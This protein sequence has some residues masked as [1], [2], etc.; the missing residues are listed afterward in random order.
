MSKFLQAAIEY[1]ENGF[2]VIPVQKNKKPYIK[3][4]R[5]Q[6]ERA[7]QEQLEQWW[8]QWPEANVGI[9]TGKISGIM[10][11][12]ADSKQGQKELNKLFPDSLETPTAKSPGGWH[13][14]FAYQEGLSNTARVLPDCDIRTDG[15]YI[16]APPSRNAKGNYAWVE[17]LSIFDVAPAA[18]PKPVYNKIK[19]FNRGATNSDHNNPQQSATIRNISF[20]EGLRDESLFHIGNCL[21]KGGMDSDNALKCL[22]FIG[23]N[24][25]PPFPEKEIQAKIQSVFKRAKNKNRSLTADVREYVS[26]TWGNISATEVAQN[27]TNATLEDRKKIRVILGRLVKEKILVRVSNLNGVYR[28]VDTDIEEMNFL[29]ADTETVDLWLPFGLNEKAEIMPGNIIV[30]AGS[31]DAGKTGLLLNVIRQNMQKF[32]I[33]YFNSEMGSG[34]LN[35]RLNNFDD[36]TLDMWKFKAWER[37][38]NFADVIKPGKGKINIID[39]LEIHDN[40]Y[41]VGGRLAEIHK[42]LKDAIAIVALQKNPGAKAGLGGYR[43]L[44]KPRLYLSMDSGIVTITKCKNWATSENPNGLQ[45]RFKVAGG[46][47]FIKAQDWHRPVE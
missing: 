31:P 1:C 2:S 19:A 38:D 23:S 14:Y 34:E 29:D 32:E 9:V 16:I 42:K 26:A 24:C 8:G 25:N 22:H 27:A 11:L 40:F 10:V 43:S 37:S 28:K 6:G 3:W 20:E 45:Y 17:G 7:T 44:E 4:E 36:L 12:D 47:K 13:N 33:H 35:K 15:G 18:L 41:E 21:I 30:I 46:C 5:Y 39:F